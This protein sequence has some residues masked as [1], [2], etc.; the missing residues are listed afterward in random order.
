MLSH[1][2]TPVQKGS[3]R[4]PI[5]GRSLGL[6]LGGALCKRR[7]HRDVASGCEDFI[8]PDR[9]RCSDGADVKSGCMCRH[10]LN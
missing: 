6:R 5:G 3:D 1:L 7:W 8:V 2:N 4:V 9:G 10:S